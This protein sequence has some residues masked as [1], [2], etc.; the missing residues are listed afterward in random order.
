MQTESRLYVISILPTSRFDYMTITTNPDKDK[1][2]IK[3]E[4]DLLSVKCLT[5]SPLNLIQVDSSVQV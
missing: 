4:T 2:D 3:L 1:L 5:D